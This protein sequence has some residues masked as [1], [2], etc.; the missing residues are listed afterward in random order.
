MLF[1]RSFTD[2]AGEHETVITFYSTYSDFYI[3]K[4]VRAGLK[5]F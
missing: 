5:R 1:L 4:L 3:R 2:A